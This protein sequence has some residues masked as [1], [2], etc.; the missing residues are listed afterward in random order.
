MESQLTLE[1]ALGRVEAIADS[2]AKAIAS[3]TK[4]LKAVRTAAHTGKLRDLQRSLANVVQS[5]DALR[6]VVKELGESWHFDERRYFE[7]GQYTAELIETARNL[8]VRV[9]QD[10][11]RVLSYPCIVRVIASESAVDIDRKR[12]RA[13]RPSVLAAELRK[14]QE[15]TPRF[16]AEHFL[17]T[18]YR[19]YRLKLAEN[20]L[21]PGATVRLADI[22]EL[23]TLGPGAKDYTKPEFARDLYLLDRSGTET[24][25]SGHR[26]SLPAATGTKGSGVLTT[27]TVDGE[28]KLYYGLA[29]R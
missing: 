6:D 1:E 20:G 13:I 14:Q 25:R 29:F 16:K 21:E 27:V 24:T 11:D 4:E 28:M 10:D 12:L 22:Y 2:A 18:L 23:L 19:A 7:S 5:A 15:R 3:T 8:G 9:L 26:V 17:E